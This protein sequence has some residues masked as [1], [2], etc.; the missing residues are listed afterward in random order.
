[1]TEA[2]MPSPPRSHVAAGWLI[3]LL[4]AACMGV[5]VVGELAG[6]PTAGF[7]YRS[8]YLLGLLFA[9]QLAGSARR[10]DSDTA[11]VEAIEEERHSARATALGELLYL[12]PPIALAILAR[13]AYRRGWWGPF[14][15]DA[16]FGVT[17]GGEWQPLPGAARAISSA[18]VAGAVGWGVR[19]F[20]TLLLGKEAFGL[21]D[22]YIMA[23]AGAIAGWGVVVF[24]FFV[25]A[26]FALAGVI[27]LLLVKRS[28]AIP[29]GP[30]LS[31]G[32]VA[33][34]ISYGAVRAYLEQGFEGLFEAISHLTGI[35]AK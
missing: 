15:W 4:A 13:V 32:I 14:D 25:A 24:G 5:I 8:T 34:L 6:V 22:V 33:T 31:L 1:M 17:I 7:Q 26:F 12:V 11:V 10:R 19:I 27:L 35:G 20:F 29:F 9:F 18:L 30:W 21:G 2:P 28:R 3:A 23:A 16:L